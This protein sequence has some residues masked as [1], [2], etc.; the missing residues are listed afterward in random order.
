MGGIL[1]EQQLTRRN[2]NSLFNLS[3]R[4]IWLVSS[5]LTKKYSDL[6]VL[7]QIYYIDRYQQF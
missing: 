4:Q 6:V 5:V 1:P 7:L 3:V 2:V